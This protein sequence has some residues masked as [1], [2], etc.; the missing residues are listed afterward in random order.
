MPGYFVIG[1]NPAVG[2]A[3]ARMQRQGLANLEW[4]VVRD[5]NMIET[6]TFWKD[7]PEIATGELRTEDIGTEVFFLPA[8]AH[9]EKDGT[10]TNTQRLLQW[11]HKA[12][13]PPGDCRS[14][15]WFYYEL[16]RRIKERLAGSDR[17]ARPAAAGP[18]LGLPRRRRAASRAPTPCCARSTAS[19]ADGEA[20]PGY[21]ALKA[22][23]STAC[24][25]WIYC[26]VYADGVNQSDAPQAR[27]TSRTSSPPSG[28]GRGR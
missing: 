28:A 1:E 21:T 19:D 12:V 17:S 11:H 6:A 25:C 3:N 2:T 22:D 10:F 16:G 8:A 13:E 26:G 15:L 20:L 18:D 7:G 5:L 14:D 24:G 4:L 9:T 27:R 23:G